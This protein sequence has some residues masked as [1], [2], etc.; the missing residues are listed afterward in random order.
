MIQF[1]CPACRTLNKSPDDQ[2][3]GKAAC[4]LC[5]QRLLIP[6]PTPAITVLGQLVPNMH[7]SG[8]G[9]SEPARKQY[10]D[11][12]RKKVLVSC[13]LCH[14]LIRVK[15]KYLGRKATC[16]ACGAA[17]VLSLVHTAPPPAIPFVSAVA[18]SAVPI[19]SASCTCP[20][21][22]RVIPLQQHELHLTFECARCDTIF[23]PANR[24][25]PA[26]ASA[27]SEGKTYRTS[28]L[29]QEPLHQPLP[30]ERS[31]VQN[32]LR[33]IE[34]DEPPCQQRQSRQ[35][36]EL[37]RCRV[38][39]MASAVGG[40]FA[41]CL[42]CCCPGS[43]L[44]SKFLERH[45]GRCPNCHYEFTVRFRNEYERL[46]LEERCPNCGLKWPAGYLHDEWRKAHGLEPLPV[47]KP[48]I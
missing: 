21:C 25:A 29:P 43:I 4:K 45:E 10:T 8:S 15:E 14:R 32:V 26:D 17:I 38:L 9:S 35:S 37:S 31:P 46:M 30:T 44:I 23:V 22:G 27:A 41:L 5:G 34:C 19:E 2:A 16:P 40:L 12:V 48:R 13:S 6:N 36:P 39:H 47:P 42:L 20:G 1:A 11:Q 3:G 33:A 7:T 28:E 24:I 18:S